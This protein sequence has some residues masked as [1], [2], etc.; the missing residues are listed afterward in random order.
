MMEKKNSVLVIE[1]DTAIRH[2]LFHTLG[3]LGFAVG[4]AAN[5]EEGLTR[6]RMAA[7]DAVLLDM[8][9]PGMGGMETC[10]RISEGYPSLPVIMLT[11][12]NDEADIVAALDAGASDYVVK[13]FQMGEL[14]AR[15]RAA[16]RRY[17]ASCEEE[18][19]LC[20][21]GE[22]TLDP[23][24][25]RVSKRGL[26]IRLSPREYETMHYMMCHADHVLDHERLLKA[27]WG[28]VYGQEREYLRVVINQLRKKIEDDPA[29]PSYIVTVSHVGYCLRSNR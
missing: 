12:R 2:S 21:V 5:G 22:L 13:P 24:L 25:R 23:G 15:I 3:A 20:V 6:L 1:D 29:A 26:A 8:N 9:M 19:G 16:I 10:R 27:V 28:P 14:T 11:V 17:E 4:A 7:Y 18:P